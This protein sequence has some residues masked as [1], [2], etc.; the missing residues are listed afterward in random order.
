MTLSSFSD[1][2]KNITFSALN[3]KQ[4]EYDAADVTILNDKFTRSPFHA[5]QFL[6]AFAG[7]SD[8]QQQQ[9]LSQLAIPSIDKEGLQALI[10]DIEWGALLQPPAGA[11][12]LKHSFSI[13]LADSDDFLNAV[14]K[15]HP[16]LYQA[17]L[18]ATCIVK[19]EQ[20]D[21]VVFTSTI[22]QEEAWT[23]PFVRDKREDFWNVPD[24]GISPLLKQTIASLNENQLV[25]LDGF[26]IK[27]GRGKAAEH[28]E[29]LIIAPM[30]SNQFA[31][32]SKIKTAPGIY[33]AFIGLTHFYGLE[34][35]NR[36]EVEIANAAHFSDKGASASQTQVTRCRR[37]NACSG[38]M[39]T[40][41]TVHA[42]NVFFCGANIIAQFT[43]D[44][45]PVAHSGFN[46]QLYIELPTQSQENTRVLLLASAPNPQ[47]A[48]ALIG[49]EL[50]SYSQ[51]VHKK[52][53]PGISVSAAATDDE[54]MIF[55]LSGHSGTLEDDDIVTI[56]PGWV[57]DEQPEPEDLSIPS[58]MSA[59]QPRRLRRS[60]S[61]PEPTIHQL[62]HLIERTIG[63]ST[64]CS[65]ILEYTLLE[66]AGILSALVNS[67]IKCQFIGANTPPSR[68]A[69]SA[70]TYGFKQRVQNQDS[71]LLQVREAMQ[72]NIPG[73]SIRTPDAKVFEQ[74][75][76]FIVPNLILKNAIETSSLFRAA[77]ELSA[78][79]NTQLQQLK[80]G[81]LSY[82]VSDEEQLLNKKIAELVE[83]IDGILKASPLIQK[84]LFSITEQGKRK[85]E[86]NQTEASSARLK[87][88]A[89]KVIGSAP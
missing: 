33:G 45:K 79:D 73:C 87:T 62:D 40:V 49:N 60:W 74:Q 20:R 37:Q 80:A 7:L 83:K 23:T 81:V 64:D 17:L 2:Q 51:P 77:G 28:I 58:W 76:S 88:D 34:Q 82:R 31:I 13:A 24:Y 61:P 66:K 29:L 19:I 53:A 32:D 38:S 56:I 55:P 26:A 25:S 50:P 44:K 69:K 67:T 75:I 68:E 42:L 59:E 18:H 47:Q 9:V 65:D 89:D 16:H 43:K 70:V 48:F 46:G 21:E 8:S 3:Q 54:P 78:L 36:V 63:L 71:K 22:S 30:I 35:V 1:L 27:K 5:I 41:I 84:G 15:K 6:I 52:Q 39:N 12:V 86:E 85:P 57:P 11:K 4:A 10:A 14:E 72:R